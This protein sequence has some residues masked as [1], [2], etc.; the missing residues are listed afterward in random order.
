MYDAAAAHARKEPQ[1]FV[2]KVTTSHIGNNDINRMVLQHFQG[3]VG[4]GRHVHRHL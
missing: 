3:L 2:L 4:S 1:A